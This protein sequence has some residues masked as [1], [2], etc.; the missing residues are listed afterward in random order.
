VSTTTIHN[1]GV[2]PHQMYSP[3]GHNV[4]LTNSIGTTSLLPAA[5]LEDCDMKR[6]AEAVVAEMAR[7]MLNI[8]QIII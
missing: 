8:M 5:C 4:S 1:G 7:C 2:S 6:A 3:L